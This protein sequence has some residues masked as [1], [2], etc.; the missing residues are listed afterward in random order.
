MLDQ[1]DVGKKK[2]SSLN[3][4]NFLTSEPI[5]IKFKIESIANVDSESIAG[6]LSSETHKQE[7]L[8]LDLHR[9]PH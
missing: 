7:T 4:H 5:L 9:R 3:R 1:S 2:I 6:V 8:F